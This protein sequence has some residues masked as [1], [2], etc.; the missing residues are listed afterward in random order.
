MGYKREEYGALAS[1]LRL[2][3]VVRAH[4]RHVSWL[5]LSPTSELLLVDRRLSTYAG[6]RTL[7]VSYPYRNP[8][9]LASTSL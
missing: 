9:T 7:G 2:L 3:P 5:R 1:L 4:H 8:S 6:V